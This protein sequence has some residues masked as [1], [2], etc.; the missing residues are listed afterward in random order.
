MI[1]PEKCAPGTTSENNV[2]LFIDD[3]YKKNVLLRNSNYL[4]FKFK[5]NIIQ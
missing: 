1:R 4:N 2:I 5:A 3:V